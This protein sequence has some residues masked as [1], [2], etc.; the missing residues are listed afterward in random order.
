MIVGEIAQRARNAVAK[1]TTP[2]RK[3]PRDEVAR[4][5]PWFL[6]GLFFVILVWERVWDLSDNAA[7]STW[8]LLLITAGAVACF[9][10]RLW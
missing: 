3:W 6:Y 7:L 5:G 9:E 10:H 2:L 8:L 1:E 4:W